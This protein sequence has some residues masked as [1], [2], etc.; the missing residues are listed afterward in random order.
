MWC[1]RSW[2]Q[3]ACLL[4]LFRGSSGASGPG[5]EVCS[6]CIKVSLQVRRWI[7]HRQR[8]MAA[9]RLNTIGP[10]SLFDCLQSDL[11]A[12]FDCVLRRRGPRRHHRP[13]VAHGWVCPVLQI[14]RAEDYVPS[15]KIIMLPIHV[16][17]AISGGAL[18]ISRQ[19]WWTPRTC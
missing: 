10:S 3:E 13:V 7:P 6:A 5:S 17:I 11:L 19:S 1:L 2:R 18:R 16:L 8:A 12:S 4:A 14:P 15:S 9:R